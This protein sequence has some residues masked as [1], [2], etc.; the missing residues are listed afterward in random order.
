MDESYQ[1]FVDDPTPERFLAARRAVIDDPGYP[2][3][4]LPLVKLERLL[5][6][7]QFT[8]LA[9]ETARLLHAWRLSPRMHFLAGVAAAELGRTAR[10][11]EQRRQL[12]ACLQGLLG[13]GDGTRERPFLVTHASDEYDVVRA[14]GHQPITQQLVDSGS[15]RM[16]V[17]GCRGGIEL[18]FDVTA[19]LGAAPAAVQVTARRSRRRNPVARLS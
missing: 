2:P 8:R 19:L 6:A 15:R 17:I 3:D 4:G 9:R 11:S 14:L 5:D 1:A 7:A 10:A 16:D 13:T 12:Q 18:W